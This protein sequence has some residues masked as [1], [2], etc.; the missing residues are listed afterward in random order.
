MISIIVPV[1]NMEKYL[2][3][4]VNSILAQSYGDFELLLVDDGSTD[5]SG[6]MCDSFARR[7][8]RIRVIHKKNGG[9]AEARNL[10]LDQIQG[11]YVTFADSDDY[12]G[13]DY[14]KVLLALMENDGV[15]ISVL[16]L[17]C[18]TTEQTVFSDSKD[19]RCIWDRSQAFK[20]MILGRKTGVS[21]C[22]KLY[23]RELFAQ[24]RFPLGTAYEDL[25]L[26]PYLV[27]QCNLLAYS[28][29]IQYY[30][31]QRAGSTMHALTDAK[32]DQWNAGMERI[33]QYAAKVYPEAM[34]CINCRY[35]NYGLFAI[36][37]NSFGRDDYVPK[38]REF[39]RR[40]S[41]WWRKA[42]TNPYLTRRE[43]LR[44]RLF[45]LSPGLYRLMHIAYHRI[46]KPK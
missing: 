33:Y 25:E 16:A 11:E 35:S 12:V 44:T 38:A 4:C 43:K 22:A 19:E 5:A 1:Y 2:D 27:E 39:Q 10:A 26:I 32:I 37:H 28:T 17:D 29:S 8:G 13:P 3:R 45:L 36:I 31:Y 46:K 41:D 23:K 18:V 24:N 40:H 9:Q 20:E 15:D 14:L 34:D 21:P 42:L 30:Y 7:D 6:A